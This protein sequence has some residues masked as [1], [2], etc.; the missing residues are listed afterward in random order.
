MKPENRKQNHKKMES[1]FGF[2]KSF[3]H[4]FNYPFIRREEAEEARELLMEIYL[5][6]VDFSSFKLLTFGAVANLLSQWDTTIFSLM[7]IIFEKVEK[8]NERVKIGCQVYLLVS[9]VSRIF[10]E[11]ISDFTILIFIFLSFQFSSWENWKM[12]WKEN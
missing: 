2:R 6:L 12:L 1:N 9:M 3:S 8:W 11:L 10:R 4:L 7:G 5:K